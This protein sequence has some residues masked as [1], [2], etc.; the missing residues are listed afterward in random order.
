MKFN[1]SGF[2]VV[3]IIIIVAVL[4][5]LA[6]I[7][8]IGW[9]SVTSGMRDQ[10]RED[11][12]KQWVS[13]FELYK[14]RFA[15]WPALPT[16]NGASGAVAL[17]LDS[18][19]QSNN[20]FLNKCVQYKSSNSSRY[21]LVSGSNDMKMEIEKVGKY[22]VNSGPATNE[23][24]AGP[25]VLLTQST[26]G[27]TTTVTGKFVGFFEGNCPQGFT[28]V[29]NNSDFTVLFSGLPARG[30]APNPC[31]LSPAPSFSFRPN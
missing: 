30:T 7:I 1:R 25:F 27:G 13:T 29:R 28:N 4:A 14:S 17:C 3:E 24:A 31:M 12:V 10:A 18:P 9:S 21:K 8:A 16:G 6:A 11:D 5:I 22:P 2:S 19:L 20:T 15:V 26:S 23:V